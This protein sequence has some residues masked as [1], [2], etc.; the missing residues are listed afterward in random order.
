VGLVL[1]FVDDAGL[2][3][4][5]E[6]AGE[7]ALSYLQPGVSR[8]LGSARAG[9]FRVDSCGIDIGGDATVLFD[10]ATEALQSWAVHRGAGLRVAPADAPLA[11]GVSVVVA[12]KLPLVT[13]IAPCR[14]VWTVDEVERF[15]FA[16]GTLL[17]HPEA[18]EESFVVTRTAVGIRF[19]IVAVS[20][21]AEFLARVG[22]RVTRQIQRRTTSRYLSALHDSVARRVR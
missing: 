2:A 7:L 14:I 16:Y 17:G 12:I 6:R 5:A 8:D 18:G 20:R 11:V 1:G 4:E 15:G 22:S 13:A 10:A 21:P 19:E 9:G 3:R